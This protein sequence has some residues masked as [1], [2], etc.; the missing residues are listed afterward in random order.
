MMRRC[1]ERWRSSLTLELSGSD[2]EV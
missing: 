1:G 2:N